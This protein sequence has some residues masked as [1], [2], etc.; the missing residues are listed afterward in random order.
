MA[1]RSPSVG[2][3]LKKF[4]RGGLACRP[5]QY[6]DNNRRG[7]VS[8]LATNPAAAGRANKVYLTVASRSSKRFDNQFGSIWGTE[9]SKRSV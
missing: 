2:G 4:F 3:S 7:R 9:D 5:E 6:R 1:P 8:S